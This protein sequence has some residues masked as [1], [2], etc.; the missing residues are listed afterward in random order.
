MRYI[1]TRITADRRDGYPVEPGQYR[2]VVS[3]A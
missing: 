1:T 3:R 2:L